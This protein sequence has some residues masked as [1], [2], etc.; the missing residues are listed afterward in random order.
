MVFIQNP[1]YAKCRK[2]FEDVIRYNGV[3]TEIFDSL[4]K[5][6]EINLVNTSNL[7]EKWCMIQTIK[8]LKN[9]YGFILQDDWQRQLIK[10]VL[11]KEYNILIKMECI[12]TLQKIDLTFEKRTTNQ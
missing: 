10:S 9:T 4:M 8:I 2:Q 5:I 12:N 7:Y 1:R 3:S 11:N 6:N